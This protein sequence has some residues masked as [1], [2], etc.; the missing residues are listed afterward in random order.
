MAAEPSLTG[1]IDAGIRRSLEAAVA[2]IRQTYGTR[3]G[4]GRGRELVGCRTAQ[5]AEH[6]GRSTGS[7]RRS[8]PRPPGLQS[9]NDNTMP[10]RMAEYCLGMLRLFGKFPRQI[11]LYV[12]EAPLRMESEL[13]GPD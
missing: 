6:P 12:G 9:G 10:L 8:R 2:R 1:K 7:H 5:S 4:R 3:V 11:V 13:R